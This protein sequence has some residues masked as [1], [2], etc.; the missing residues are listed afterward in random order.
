MIDT[1]EGFYEG[2]GGSMAAA[3]CG[4]TPTIKTPYQAYLEFVDPLCRPDLSSNEQVEAGVELE[5]AIGK[6][7]A[8]KWGISVVREPRLLKHPVTSF[9]QAHIDFLVQG[10]NAFMEVKNRGIRARKLY[11]EYQ[12]SEDDTDNVQ[13]GEAIQVQHYCG[14]GGYDYGYLAVLVGGQSLLRFKLK[15]DEEIIAMIQTKCREFWHCVQTRTPPPPMTVADTHG[16][17]PTHTIGKAVTADEVLLT[18]VD[19]RARMKAAIKEN[20]DALKFVEL[21]LKSAMQDAEVLEFMGKP[22]LTWKGH[23]TARFDLD[24]FRAEHP[25]LAAQYTKTEI[26]RTMRVVKAKKK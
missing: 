8:K 1:P 15:R 22:L 2:I 13:A 14:V 26:V 19:D 9:L 3:I 12:D 10:E 21:R 24:A 25:E 16:M 18:A 11:E 20:E 5:E 4:M 17:W 23:D 7:A 6:W